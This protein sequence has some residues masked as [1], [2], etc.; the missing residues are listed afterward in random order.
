MNFFKN[1][2]KSDLTYHEKSS[3]EEINI[4]R[5]VEEDDAE[6]CAILSWL[7]A[8]QQK[9]AKKK[10]GEKQESNDGTLR[11]A[12]EEGDGTANQATSPVDPKKLSL[13]E[14]LDLWEK[15]I[16]PGAD[17]DAADGDSETRP[18][19][20]QRIRDLLSAPSSDE[21]GGDA[22]TEPTNQ[23]EQLQWRSDEGEGSTGGG[24]GG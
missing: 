9:K 12:S 4:D 6:T 8:E 20:A 17:D 23:S 7:D 13:R 19:E 22:E 18:D 11:E 24:D 5:K 15:G 21:E 16:S 1:F 3:F 2:K 10:N 14:R